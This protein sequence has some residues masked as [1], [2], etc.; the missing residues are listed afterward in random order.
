[1]K[2]RKGG[3]EE[4]KGRGVKRGPHFFVQVYAPDAVLLFVNEH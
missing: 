3:E 2:R 4:K 1:M